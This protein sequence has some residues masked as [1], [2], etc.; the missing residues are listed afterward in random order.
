M[1]ASTTLDL[2]VSGRQER[3]ED[4]P[5]GWPQLPDGEHPWRLDGRP[6]AQWSRTGDRRA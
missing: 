2:T 1:N 4:S 5:G 3:W 6:I